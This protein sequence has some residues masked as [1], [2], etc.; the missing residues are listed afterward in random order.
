[1]TR[2]L[3]TTDEHDFVVFDLRLNTITHRQPKTKELDSLNLQGKGRPTYRPF[4]VD[5]DD[6]YIYIASN[7]KL[8]KFDKTSYEF[9]GLIP[10]PMVINTH[11]IVKDQDTF[12][13]CHTAIDTIGIHDVKN[14]IN[15]YI[16]VNLLNR[17][18]IHLQPL[19]ADQ[20]DS[21]HLNSLFDAGDKV[22]FCRHNKN[23]V[24]SDFGYF[25]KVNTFD[26]KL[27]ARAGKC[28]HGIRVV[29]NYL[30]TLST[31]TGEI[32][33]IDL[34]TNVSK[35]F[36]L[37]DSS[38]TFLRGLDVYDDKIIIGCSVN[39]KTNTKDQSCYIVVVD[40]KNNTTSKYLIDGIKF[41]N[42]LKVVLD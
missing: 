23:L 33:M 19:N 12:Y 10:L 27:V 25:D 9:K 40:I 21:R 24:E 11:Q 5:V 26:I 4:G 39:F 18:D 15:K 16:N 37:V 35:P 32:L 7:D 13:I 1:M 3:I 2:L 30:Y 38:S 42:D 34:N 28:C 29:D 17:V 6:Q 41:I 22:Y 8:G 36:K 14:K 20:L 31:G